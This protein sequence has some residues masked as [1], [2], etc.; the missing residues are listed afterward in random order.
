MAADAD[1]VAPGG[2]QGEKLPP[3]SL[4]R[5]AVAIPLAAKRKLTAT[6][7]RAPIRIG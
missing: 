2:L 1:P 4:Q 7:R 6:A 3:S 5:K